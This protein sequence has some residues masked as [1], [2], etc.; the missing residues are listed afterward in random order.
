[1]SEET[2]FNAIR[3]LIHTV[4]ENPDR[5]GLVDTPKRS[6]KAF[7]EMA[8]GYDV[9]I[10]ELL[11]VTFSEAAYDEMIV[12]ANVPFV[13]L[14]EH[15]LLPFTGTVTVGYIPSGGKIVGLSKIPR[16]VSGLSKRL[17][18]QERLT[19]EIADRFQKN[20]DPLGVGVIVK[21]NHSCMSLRGIRSSGE[22]VTSCLR[23]VFRDDPK[24]RAEFL[25]LR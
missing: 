7:K 3:E 8:S 11:S 14:C 18:V 25:D 2:V 5:E 21:G 10:D 12:V 19:V 15:H 4:G 1:M 17:Q 6:V 16:A 23:G 9:D 20:V 13:S 22:M 24:V